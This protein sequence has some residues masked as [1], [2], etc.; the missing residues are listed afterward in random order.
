[1][2]IRKNPNSDLERKK[3]YLF[4]IGM[5]ITLV[6]VMS[7]FEYKSYEKT[8]VIFPREASNDIHEEFTQI[9]IQKEKPLPAVKKINI[10]IV[11]DMMED[12]GE[13]NIDAQAYDDTPVPE[14]IPVKINEEVIPD[15]I[16]VHIPEIMPE[17]PGGFPAMYNFLREHVKY[18]VY[19]KELGFHGTV[20]LK[21]VVEK[22]GSITNVEVL[23]GVGGGCNEE[24]I[25]VVKSMPNWS[26]GMQMGRPVRVIYN[27]PIKFTLQ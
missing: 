15:D 6:A 9:T 1:M 19:A 2:E 13:V 26:P 7:A 8:E 22:D 14:Y 17:F 18:P 16:P 20:F 27:L 10:N 12:P 4:Q 21:F 5:I 3:T 25:R 23:R 11:D 24:A